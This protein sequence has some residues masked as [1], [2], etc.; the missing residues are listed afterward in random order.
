MNRAFCELGG[1]VKDW[2]VFFVILD[3]SCCVNGVGDVN[4]ALGD[5]LTGGMR[6]LK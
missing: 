2:W 4:R 6:L 3:R 1:W 5:G